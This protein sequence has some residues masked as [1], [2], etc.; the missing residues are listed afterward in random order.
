MALGTIDFAGFGVLTCCRRE[1]PLL[2]FMF[3]DMPMQAVKH[4]QTAVD[5]TIRLYQKLKGDMIETGSENY[6]DDDQLGKRSNQN[7][8]EILTVLSSAH[9]GLGKALFALGKLV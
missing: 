4:S 2:C 1:V 3:E 7:L 8:I 6:G 5:M 9:F